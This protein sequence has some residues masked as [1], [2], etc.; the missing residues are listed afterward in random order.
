MTFTLDG[1][2]V[3]Q[4]LVATILPIMVG[5]VTT[6]VTSAGRKAW[7]LAALSLV[8]SVLVEW[9]SALNAKETFDIG[10]AL[11]AAIP[12]FAVSVATHYGLWKP[13]G[14]SGA[15]QDTLRKSP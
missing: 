5:L 11:I 12:T 1:A 10:I 8:T 2:A 4:L 13:T 3:I 7:L 15:A 6:R 9:G 14:V